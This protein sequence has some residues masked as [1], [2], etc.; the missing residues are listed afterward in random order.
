MGGDTMTC[1]FDEM[2]LYEY[3]DDALD[4]EDKIKVSNH[5]S[6]CPHCRQKL[7]EIKL[8]YYELDHLEEVEIPDALEAVKKDAI[9][10][11][12][13]TIKEKKSIGDKLKNTQ[14]TLL[15]TPVVNHLVPTKDKLKKTSIVLVESSKKVIQKVPKKDKKKKA[16]KERFGGLL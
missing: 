4:S 1:Q 3:L 9:L 8:M 15:E 14:A 12:S 6:A 16:L 2:L 7:A 13:G 10:A 5:L 11:V